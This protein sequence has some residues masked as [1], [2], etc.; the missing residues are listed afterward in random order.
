MEVVYYYSEQI[1]EST[2]PGSSQNFEYLNI[3]RDCNFILVIRLESRSCVKTLDSVFLLVH[4][5]EMWF[6]GFFFCKRQK[7]I[8]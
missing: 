1:G 7:D 3:C 5:L 4:P 8:L 6:S 2:Q